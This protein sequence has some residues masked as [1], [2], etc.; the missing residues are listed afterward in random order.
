MTKMTDSHFSELIYFPAYFSTCC[1]PLEKIPETLNNFLW[2]SP[3]MVV[4]LRR[5]SAELTLEVLLL[6][7]YFNTEIA[8][9]FSIVFSQNG[10]ESKL[11]Y[12]KNGKEVDESLF[13]LLWTLISFT[14]KRL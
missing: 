11:I 4:S 12:M 13:E 10:W 7:D 1:V 14:K 5:G 3:G 8:K 9:D 6:P 2:F